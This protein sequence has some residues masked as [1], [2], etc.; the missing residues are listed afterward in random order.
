MLS[1]RLLFLYHCTTATAFS[2]TLC[3]NI[4]TPQRKKHFHSPGVT[5]YMSISNDLCY[6]FLKNRIGREGN[7]EFK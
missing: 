2:L 4:Q 3:Y 6:L 1:F 5:Y 7:R